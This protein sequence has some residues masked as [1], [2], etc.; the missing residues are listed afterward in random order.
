MSCMSVPSFCKKF[1]EQT[2]M[3]VTQYI[4]EKRVAYASTLLKQSKYSLEEVRSWRVFPMPI[5]FCECLKRA[6][7]RP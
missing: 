2:K 6:P 4:N 1:K 7:E 5:I 3:T